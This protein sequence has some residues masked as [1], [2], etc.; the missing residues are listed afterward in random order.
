MHNILYIHY[1]V[2]IISLYLISFILYIIVY[3]PCTLILL[4]IIYYIACSSLHYI[5]Y[6]ITC[7]IFC[8]CDINTN[9]SQASG[10][11]GWRAS[12]WAN[13][14]DSCSTPWANCAPTAARTH[15]CSTDETAWRTRAWT[16][17]AVQ[18]IPE[19]LAR[20]ERLEEQT[21]WKRPLAITGKRLAPSWRRSASALS[22]VWPLFSTCH[23]LKVS[24]GFPEGYPTRS[25]FSRHPSIPTSQQL[26]LC[27][28][29]SLL[30][31]KSN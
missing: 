5:L 8:V 13:R 28:P 1:I 31:W 10:G 27:R 11:S 15:G 3:I 30:S 25:Q 26:H 12:L 14:A 6:S 2:Y 7:T 24:Q 9:C 4:S 23:R 20:S 29:S 18:N 16:T 17:L 19:L 22:Q 21:Q